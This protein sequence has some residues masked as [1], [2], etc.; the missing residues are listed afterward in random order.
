[1]PGSPLF[2]AADM[3]LW[4][5]K[6]AEARVARPSDEIYHPT[7]PNPYN[8]SANARVWA[9][10]SAW[11]VERL[12]RIR[13]RPDDVLNLLLVA[14]LE[15]GSTPITW[16]EVFE[17]GLGDRLKT[18]DT[19]ETRKHVHTVLR[20]LK[21]VPRSWAK[22]ATTRFFRGIGKQGESP[23]SEKPGAGVLSKAY[24]WKTFEAEWFVELFYRDPMSGVFFADDSVDPYSEEGHEVDEEGGNRF[25]ATTKSRDDEFFDTLIGLL[26]ARG[27][28]IEIDKPDIPAPKPHKPKVFQ[29]GDVITAR[30]L[31]DLPVGSHIRWIMTDYPYG[32]RAPT[33]TEFET[34]ERTYEFVLVERQPKELQVRPVMQGK[35]FGIRP[36]PSSILYKTDYSRDETEATYLGPWTGEVI[37]IEVSRDGWKPKTKKTKRRR[38][39]TYPNEKFI[40]L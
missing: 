31:R 5:A 1:M 33:T 17:G 30:N 25:A 16:E 27:L 36:M 6:K 4:D 38:E 22:S 40:R 3:S 10:E 8:K 18:A 13:S 26:E 35:A 34:E 19:P 29:P 12:R 2:S 15:K 20:G 28:A 24:G 14:F 23:W 9:I 7:S 39:G 32:S 11:R 21:A 37:D